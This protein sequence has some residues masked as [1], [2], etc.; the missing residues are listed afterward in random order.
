MT[1][2]PSKP[3][4]DVRS[5]IHT[6]ALLENDPRGFAVTWI[7]WD[8]DFRRALRFNDLITAV[9]GRSL[10]PFLQPGKLSKGVG[11]YAEGQYW[12]EI[13]AAGGQEIILTVC[14]E[15]V[16]VE[17]KGRLGTDWFHYDESGK[18]ALGPGGPGRL[19]TDGFSEAWM[20]WLEKLQLKLSL[21]FTSGWTYKGLN[22]RNELRALLDEQ[23]RIDYLVAHWPGPFAQ[24]THDDWARAVEIVRGKLADPPAD[25]E[26]RAIGARRVEVAKAEAAKAW[27]AVLDATS[28]DRVPA[29]PAGSP[30][31]RETW[32]GKIVEFPP[33]SYSNFRSDL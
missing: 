14:R 30:L 26:Y 15:D 3:G 9:N 8:S 10:A 2:P 17:V 12:E 20:G 13:G 19:A 24:I 21:I 29:T 4:T 27:T 28:K 22:N 7:D 31:E 11:Q 32:V 25:L 33:L 5:G 6:D 23:A 18:P 1:A 16:P